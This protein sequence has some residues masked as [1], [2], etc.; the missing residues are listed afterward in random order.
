MYGRITGVAPRVTL[1]AGVISLS[2]ARTIFDAS[3]VIREL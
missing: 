2:F 1:D 3:V